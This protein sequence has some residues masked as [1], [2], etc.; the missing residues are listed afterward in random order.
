MDPPPVEEKKEILLR[1]DHPL[2]ERFQATLKAHLLRVQ[3]KLQ[4]ECLDLEKTLKTREEEQ[5]EVGANLYDVQQQIGYQRRQLNELTTEIQERAEKR[6]KL[7]LDVEKARQNHEEVQTRLSTLS[8]KYDENLVAMVNL[9]HFEKHIQKWHEEAN[10]ALKVAN[11]ITKKDSQDKLAKIEEKRKLD[12]FVLS[13]ES[14]VRSRE[15]ELNSINEQIR[16]STTHLERFNKNLTDANADLTGLQHEQKRLMQAWGEVIVSIQ[17][18]DKQLAAVNQE[19]H[20]EYEKH[21]DL[22]GHIDGTRKEIQ[23]QSVQNEKL[24]G[25]LNRLTGDLQALERQLT[26]ETKEME[27]L[28]DLSNE[29]QL[30]YEQTE[31]DLKRSELEGVILENQLKT[32]KAKIELQA[33]NKLTLEEQILD[34][35]QEQISSDKAGQY[36]AKIL[37]QNQELRRQMEIQI[38]ATENDLSMVLLDLERV[39][40][41]V[42]RYQEMQEKFQRDEDEMKG[43]LNKQDEDLRGTITQINL[44]QRSLD[45]SIKQLEEAVDALGGREVSPEENRIFEVKQDLMALDEKMN[46]SQS[47]WL[48]L[49]Q[50][51]VHLNE[52]RSTQTNE[53]Y[54]ARK[55]GLRQGGI[56]YLTLFLTLFFFSLPPQR[57]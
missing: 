45:V 2:L 42:T 13:L 3:S 47:F 23:K 24:E 57:T 46:E 15:N 6:M 27:K 26:R 53:I 29:K 14:E 10:D 51:L 21:K 28:L 19:L 54:I 12:L 38:S 18:R 1:D 5:K 25:F 41:S 22:K 9:N 39:R 17:Q 30:I 11:R 7:N 52:K 35:L 50:H 4:E 48:K 36:R 20:Q 8:R 32:V 49:Q 34:L 44:R 33:K 37:R 43:I 56:N 40:G 16:D 55:R 31:L